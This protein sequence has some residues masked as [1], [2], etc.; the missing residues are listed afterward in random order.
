MIIPSGILDLARTGQRRAVLL[1]GTYA[2]RAGRLLLCTRDAADGSVLVDVRNVQQGELGAM[3]LRILREMRKTSMSD[4]LR[5]LRQVD[6]EIAL[7]SRVTMVEW[8][9]V[10]QVNTQ[11]PP[12]D[13]CI[14][15]LEEV[16]ALLSALRPFI[17]TAQRARSNR[18]GLPAA[19]T[20][21]ITALQ[22]ARACSA[23]HLI[24]SLSRKRQA[25]KKE[26]S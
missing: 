17:D 18:K 6:P 22:L 3:P 4:L 1:V 16:D 13:G 5:S 12:E 10:I 23:Y 24:D 19:G 7:S 2:V 15:S 20:A 8:R 25:T 21:S 11:Q 14:L 9:D 26:G